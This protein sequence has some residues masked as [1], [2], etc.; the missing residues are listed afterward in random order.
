MVKVQRPGIE[1]V[2]RT[3]L[4]ILREVASVATHRSRLGGAYDLIGVVDELASALVQELDYTAEGA[5]ADRLAHDLR[6]D[7]R[8]VIPH[9][10]WEY[11]T[12]RVLSMERIRGVRLTELDVASSEAREHLQAH[13][14]TQTQTQAQTQAQGQGQAPAQM[15][16]EVGAEADA[17][18]VNRAAIAQALAT[19]ILEQIWSMGS[20]TPTCI[21][22]T[23]SHSRTGESPSLTSG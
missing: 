22:G 16:A 18:P 13:A 3:D 2:V 7:A 10:Y 12:R 21:P 23:S 11:T 17:A 15:P 14:Q 20:S 9:V 1:R 6:A 5:N 4:E 19:A 8:V